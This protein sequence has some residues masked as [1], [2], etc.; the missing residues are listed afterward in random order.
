MHP[1]LRVVSRDREITSLL[2]GRKMSQTK[3]PTNCARRR[4]TLTPENVGDFFRQKSHNDIFVIF[5]RRK[6]I[7]PLKLKK[8]SWERDA[9][10]A[11]A[12]VV[13]VVK[14]NG[15]D[16]SAVSWWCCC[17]KQASVLPRGGGSSIQREGEGG[18]GDLTE[19]PKSQRKPP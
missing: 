1:P 8:E 16:R 19:N 12:V 15:R 3:F 13:V 6:K 5:R 10:V 11:A 2:D 4:C 17:Q 9:A 7:C 14:R 18:E